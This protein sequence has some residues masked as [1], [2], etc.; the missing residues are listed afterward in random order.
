MP[1]SCLPFIKGDNAK[2]MPFLTILFYWVFTFGWP[3]FIIFAKNIFQ[4]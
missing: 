1:F 4:K 3:V 2:D